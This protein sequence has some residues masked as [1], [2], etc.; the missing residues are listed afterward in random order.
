[1]YV[2]RLKPKLLKSA[3]R[4]FTTRRVNSGDMHT[5]ITRDV[6]P[7]AGDLV[8]ATVDELGSHQRIELPN[9]RRARLFPGDTILVC[10]ANRYAPDQFEAVVPDDL[11]PCDLVAGGGVAG[12]TICRH[13]RMNEPTRILPIGLV[14]DGAGQPLNLANYAIVTDRPARRIPVVFV[15]GTAMNAGKTVTAGSLVRGFANTGIPVAG[16]KATG[17]GSGRDLWLMKDM[18]AT[19]ATDFLDIGLAGTYLAPP[20]GIESG[21][22][23]LIDHAALSGCQV[24]IVEIADGLHHEETAALV[25]SHVLRERACGVVF[26][27]YDSLGAQQGVEMLKAHGH[28]IFALSGQI[29]RSPLA[30][31]EVESSVDVPAYSPFHL[32]YGVLNETILTAD[33]EMDKQTARLIDKVL[34]WNEESLQQRPTPANGGSVA[35]VVRVP[36]EAGGRKRFQFVFED[37]DETEV[38]DIFDHSVVGNGQLPQSA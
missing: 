28:R 29:T 24:A 10:Y 19:H 11:E 14:G 32:Q 16:I 30:M 23:R 2:E 37:E 1:M 8:L 13:E 18:G 20:E 21:V 17:T 12:R 33:G 4:A 31:R 36:G 26:A 35:R 27:A 9:G 5:L 3:K 25:R 15:L 6:Q 34:K 22:L 7:K 38:D